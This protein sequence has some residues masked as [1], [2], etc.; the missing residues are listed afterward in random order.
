[1]EQEVTRR[2]CRCNK[3]HNIKGRSLLLRNRLKPS[4]NIILK[5]PVYD[6]FKLLNFRYYVSSRNY[7]YKITHIRIWSTA[8]QK[9]VL[10]SI[11]LASSLTIN[12]PEGHIS[13]PAFWHWACW[14]F[15]N[16]LNIAKTDNIIFTHPAL[17]TMAMEIAL[18]K[19]KI[20]WRHRTD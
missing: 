11:S 2:S 16:R 6:P 1:M 19:M 9:Y 20:I 15:F 17:S 18:M 13:S 14:V 3:Q 5:H 10:I 4:W 8:S 12:H 7:F